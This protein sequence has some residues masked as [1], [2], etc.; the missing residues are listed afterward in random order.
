[1]KKTFKAVWHGIK[2]AYSTV[3]GWLNK[4]FEV[5]FEETPENQEEKEDKQ[6]KREAKYFHRLRLV[7]GT[8][9]TVI[10]AVW[11]I[12]FVIRFV[13]DISD[14][15]DDMIETDKETIQYAHIE[16]ALSDNLFYYEMNY[17]SGGFLADSNDNILLRDVAWIAKPLGGDSLVCYSD[18]NKRS[19]FHLRDGHVVAVQKYSHAWVFSDG[20]AAVEAD[21]KVKFINTEGDVVIDKRFAYDA[22]DDGYVFH[23][24]HC[25][26]NDSTGKHMGLIDRNGNWVLPPVYESIYPTDTFWLVR[27]SDAQAIITFGMDTLFPLTK[28]WFNILDTAIFVT[29]A[30]HRQSLYTLQGELMTANMIR[31]VEQLMYETDEV[32]YPTITSSEYDDSYSV[33]DPYTDKAVATCRRY[34]AEC[35]WYG[36]MAPDGK[37]ITPPSYQNIEAVGKDI[38]LCKTNYS[39]GV[40]LNSK[41]KRVE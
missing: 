24:G 37:P 2:R 19:Y 27:T 5:D 25:A 34:E 20:L 41:G 22:T 33:N 3:V 12:V 14:W 9:L 35:G 38:Y 13:E 4:V 32:V 18:G 6:R 36:L 10:V 40:I 31:D 26:V 16:E 21:G 30:D 17:C 1:M 11:A 15:I 8:G 7:A 23:K 28:G 39:H 29:Y